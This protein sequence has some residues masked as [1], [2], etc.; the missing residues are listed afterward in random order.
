MLVV[1]LVMLLAI[2]ALQRWSLRREGGDLQPALALVPA[3]A[4]DA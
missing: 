2:N 3:V 4:V 1:S